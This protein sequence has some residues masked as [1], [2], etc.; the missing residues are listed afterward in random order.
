[1]WLFDSTGESVLIVR[2]SEDKP[3]CVEIEGEDY[4]ITDILFTLV[5]LDPSALSM[6]TLKDVARAADGRGTTWQGLVQKDSD[7]ADPP[8]TYINT[9]DGEVTVG[10]VDRGSETPWILVSTEHV[11]AKDE[12]LRKL[13]AELKRIQDQI[14]EMSQ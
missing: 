2:S 6:N 14:E 10:S 3:G 9:R 13:R 7:G 8:G 11:D 4:F 12:A 5:Y 1:M